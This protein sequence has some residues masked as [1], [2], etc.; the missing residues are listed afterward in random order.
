MGPGYTDI[1][2]ASGVSEGSKVIQNWKY[3]AV[4][5]WNIFSVH[6]YRRVNF[7]FMS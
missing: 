4:Y 7:M 2:D 3:H 5:M 1:R 6:N